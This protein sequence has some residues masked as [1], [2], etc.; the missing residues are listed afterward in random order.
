[1][2]GAAGCSN[3]PGRFSTLDHFENRALNLHYTLDRRL[4]YALLRVGAAPDVE[5]DAEIAETEEEEAAEIAEPPAPPLPPGE[6]EEEEEDE[7]EPK[8]RLVPHKVADIIPAQGCGLA[9]STAA[10][11]VDG[12][13]GVDGLALFHAMQPSIEALAGRKRPVVASVALL[14]YA[15]KLIGGPAPRGVEIARI[16]DE[17]DPRVAQGAVCDVVLSCLP[18]VPENRPPICIK[19]LGEQMI[20]ERRLIF[21]LIWATGDAEI[22]R[23]WFEAIA[24]LDRSLPAKT[25][26]RGRVLTVGAGLIAMRL[27]QP[28]AEIQRRRLAEWLENIDGIEPIPDGTVGAYLKLLGA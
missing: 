23:I 25:P 27:L 17:D 14:F 9:A 11:W 6:E 10:R 4:G 21:A 26:N 18:V 20:R 24:E 5:P 13:L 1:M 12:V 22:I 19:H 16:C 15:R 28:G 7:P 2:L 3:A 8:K